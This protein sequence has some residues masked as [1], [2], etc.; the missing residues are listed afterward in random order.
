MDFLGPCAPTRPVAAV[1]SRHAELGA[2]NIRI[3]LNIHQLFDITAKTVVRNKVFLSSYFT[4]ETR[5][6]RPSWGKLKKLHPTV[7][8][9]TK[10]GKEAEKKE[11]KHTKGRERGEYNS[12]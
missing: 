6:G 8:K 7:T 3:S 5:K 4:T 10:K 11:E 2:V 1:R 9:E 12:L